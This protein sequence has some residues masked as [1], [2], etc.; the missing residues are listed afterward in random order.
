MGGKGRQAG[1][2]LGSWAAWAIRTENC[3]CPMG[4]E[5]Y[6]LRAGEED[7]TGERRE[8]WKVWA[9]QEMSSA[10]LYQSQ[11]LPSFTKFKGHSFTK[12]PGPSIPVLLRLVRQT[13]T[14]VSLHQPGPENLGRAERA[15]SLLLSQG[16]SRMLSDLQA[17][18][19]EWGPFSNRGR[20]VLV[21]LGCGDA[22]LQSGSD[23]GEC[24]PTKVPPFTTSP[25]EA[26]PS[27]ARWGHQPSSSSLAPSSSCLPWPSYPGT[28]AACLGDPQAV[29]TTE[30]LPSPGGGGG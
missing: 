16:C 1:L 7:R 15:S 11:Y 13:N 30:R 14:P 29:I 9:V 17:S 21:K 5:S 26:V 25:R 20:K 8:L 2:A 19:P 22:M 27:S 23:R 28:A 10:Y 6:A 4:T 12:L 18:L 24:W 3:G